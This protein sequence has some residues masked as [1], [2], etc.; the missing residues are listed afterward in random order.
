MP[1]ASP[2]PSPR[3]TRPPVRAGTT[4]SG[5]SWPCS[6]SSSTRVDAEAVEQVLTVDRLTD[7]AAPAALDG[8]PLSEMEGTT[9]Y[10]DTGWDPYRDVRPG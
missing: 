7:E 9:V 3:R 8:V 4:A 10:V 2:R 5:R 6:G 1:H